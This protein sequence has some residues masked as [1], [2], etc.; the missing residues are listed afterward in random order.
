[1][2]L[3]LS[4]FSYKISVALSCVIRFDSKLFSI[5]ETI[6]DMKAYTLLTDQVY[7]QILCSSVSDPKLQEVSEHICL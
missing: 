5:S 1:M 7:Y 6:K 2:C 3:Q 4:D